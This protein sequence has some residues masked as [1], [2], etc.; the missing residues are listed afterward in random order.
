MNTDLHFRFFDISQGNVCQAVRLH[1]A[2]LHADCFGGVGN[3][4][5]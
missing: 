3:V 2:K 4:D 5:C 1:V